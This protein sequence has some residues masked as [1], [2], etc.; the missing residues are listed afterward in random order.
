MPSRSGRGDL[1]AHEVFGDR[2]EV[3]VAALLVFA[4]RGLVPRRAELAAAADVGDHQHAA[5]LVPR[6]PEAA[7]VPRLHRHLEAAIAVEQRR[8]VAIVAAALGA[9]DEVRHLRPV[10]AGGEA[11]FSRHA[12]AVE[13]ARALLEHLQFVRA[14]ARQHQR[15]GRQ[16]VGVG[17][18]V[19]LGERI[20][21]HMRVVQRGDAKRAGSGPAARRG[22]A[23][24]HPP[25]AAPRPGSPP[26]RA[27]SAAHGR[28][29]THC[30]RASGSASGVNSAGPLRAASEQVVRLRDQQRASRVRDVALHQIAAQFHH[31]PVFVE[32]KAG[33]GRLVEVLQRAIRTNQPH[34]GGV[35]INRAAVD[36]TL[37]TGACRPR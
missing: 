11:L 8:V 35:E 26:D 21:R 30:R 28:G 5:A 9:D 34:L 22:A 37:E 4:D 23:T 29:S 7:R 13:V 10:G 17:D 1:R 24:G 36:D 15:V 16:E 25:A 12:V 19:V 18:P 33:V 27:R 2:D 6:Q 14:G 31:R 20:V 32:A 3:V